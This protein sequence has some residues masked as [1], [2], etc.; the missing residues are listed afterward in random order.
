MYIY[1]IYSEHSQAYI[2]YNPITKKLIVRRDVKFQEDKYWDNQI[3]EIIV[4]WNYSI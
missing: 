3:K 4:D 2:L 1:W